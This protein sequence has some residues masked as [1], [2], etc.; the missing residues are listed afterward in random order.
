MSDRLV[1]EVLVSRHGADPPINIYHVELRNDQGLW[2]ETFGSP[3]ELQTWL[4]GLNVGLRMSGWFC[5]G[6]HWNDVRGDMPDYIM[7]WIVTKHEPPV[8][9]EFIEGRL[10]SI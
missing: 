8:I 3:R 5:A 6:F 2:T 7:R 9:Q 1:I 4:D 10:V